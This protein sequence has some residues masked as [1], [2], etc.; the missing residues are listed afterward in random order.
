MIAG[1]HLDLLYMMK[2]GG[3]MTEIEVKPQPGLIVRDPISKQPLPEGQWSRV[4][5]NRYWRRQI[6]QGAVIEKP[7]TGVK[8]HKPDYENKEYKPGGKKK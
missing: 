7:I 3:N 6:L 8:L 5:Y 2:I 4:P 1:I